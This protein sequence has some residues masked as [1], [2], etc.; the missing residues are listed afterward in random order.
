M[1]TQL[2]N[3]HNSETESPSIDE[4]FEELM[5][6]IEVLEFKLEL[7]QSAQDIAFDRLRDAENRIEQIEFDASVSSCPELP[8]FELIKVK[9]SPSLRGL[10]E[11]FFVC[12]LGVSSLAALLMTVCAFASGSAEQK[13]LFANRAAIAGCVGIVAVF[14]MITLT[15]DE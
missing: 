3:G 5:D 1:E 4:R 15:G 13:D 14:G 11:R 8:P 10:T 2:L 6:R 9:R 12:S 7:S